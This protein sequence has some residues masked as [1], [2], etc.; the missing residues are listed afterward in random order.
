MQPC[1]WVLSVSEE[2]GKGGIIRVTVTHQKA[3]AGTADAR[4]KALSRICAAEASRLPEVQEFRE[5]FLGGRPLQPEEVPNWLRSR[6]E[7]GKGDPGPFAALTYLPP[8][9]RAV[10]AVPV[11]GEA[12]RE[13]KRLAGLLVRHYPWEEHQAV[14]FLLTGGI[15]EIPACRVQTRHSSIGP[16]RITIEFDVN[17]PLEEV[18]ELVKWARRQGAE[19]EFRRRRRVRPLSEHHCELAVFLAETP[20]LSWQERMERWNEG[21]DKDHPDWRYVDRRAFR[22][23]AVEAYRRITGRTWR[24]ARRGVTS[25]FP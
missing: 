1:C 8:G 13:L 20:G 14:D 25:R 18:W 19:G 15:P 5:R 2:L 22:R 11:R 17:T 9:A 3:L 4:H 23:D 7:E 12:L 21:C 10:E 24:Q 16:S 6:F